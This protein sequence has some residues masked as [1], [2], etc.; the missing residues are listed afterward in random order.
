MARATTLSV[1]QLLNELKEQVRASNDILIVG[2]DIGKYSNC[3]CF[4]SS[5]GRVYR[6]KFFFGNDRTGLN[7]LMRHTA[8]YQQKY[9][10]KG[11]LFGME[12]SGSYWKHLYQFLTDRGQIAVVVS[13]LAVRRNR[14]TIDVSKDKSDPKDAHNI[15][16]LIMQGKFYL[17]IHRDKLISQLGRYIRLYYRSASELARIK[18]RLRQVVGYVFPELEKYFTDITSKTT[19]IILNN[20]PLPSMIRSI[21]R[22]KFVL[23]VLQRNPHLGEKRA[24]EIYQLAKHSVGITAEEEA[25]LFEINLLLE[26]LGTVESKIKAIKTNIEKIVKERK[27]YQLLLTIRGIGAITAAT[28]ISEIGSIDNFSSGKQL[29]KLA[30]LDLCGSTSGTSVHTSRHISKRGRRLLRTV[31]YRAAI[32]CVRLNQYFREKYLQLLGNQADKRKIRP[33]ALVAIACKLLRVI[34]R[35]L[36][37]NMAFDPQYSEKLIAVHSQGSRKAA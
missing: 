3:A 27:D 6:R 1:K 29:I 18:I 20:Y 35:M 26:E 14:E 28:I 9:R 36:K 21:P 32:A 25:V 37:Q 5:N 8:S 19:R 15:G 30:G 7:S 2:I 22:D 34:F 16:D 31:L 17:P 10:Q 12:P 24:V 11:V 13:P 23:S 33:K 4:M